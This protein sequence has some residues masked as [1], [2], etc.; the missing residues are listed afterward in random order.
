MARK[1]QLDENIDDTATWTPAHTHALLVLLDNFVQKNHGEHP[2]MRDFKVLAEKLLGPCTK[3]FRAS[4]AKS[5]YHRMRVVYGKKLIY[6][7]G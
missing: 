4:Q 6:H 7:N 1:S 3:R 5:K 2:V